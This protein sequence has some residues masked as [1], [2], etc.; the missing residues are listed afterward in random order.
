MQVIGRSNLLWTLPRRLAAQ[1]EVNIFELPF[2]LS[3]IEM[4]LFWHKSADNDP[5]NRW[6]RELFVDIISGKD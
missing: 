1:L 5:T 4:H 3:P 6:L 2:T